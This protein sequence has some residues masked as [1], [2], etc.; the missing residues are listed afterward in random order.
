MWINYQFMLVCS[1]DLILV[2]QI[3][4]KMV[5]FCYFFGLPKLITLTWQFLYTDISVI[6]V[7]FCNSDTYTPSSSNS[8]LLLSQHLGLCLASLASI[9]LLP[10]ICYML[11]VTSTYCTLV[12]S[13]TS[14]IHPPAIQVTSGPWTGSVYQVSNPRLRGFTAGCHPISQEGTVLG[15]TNYRK[16]H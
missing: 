2:A 8:V 16:N 5:S 9:V 13:T 3:F 7:I 12:P 10:H 15:R 11:Y 1:L 14:W 4:P 6:S